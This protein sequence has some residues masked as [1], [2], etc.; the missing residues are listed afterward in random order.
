[1]KKLLAIVLALVLTLSMATIAFAANDKRT[2]PNPNVIDVDL[3]E[4]ATLTD[5]NNSAKGE[6][7]V[8]IDEG[9]LPDDAEDIDP[10]GPNKDDIVYNVV[11]DATAADFTY[12]F[13]KNYNPAT[14][15]YEGGEWQTPKSAPI[16]VTNNSN[17]SISVT[18]D[19]ETGGEKN[20]VKANLTIAGTDDNKTFTLPSAV[21]KATD[22]ATLTKDITVTI[23]DTT[24][25]ST[26]DDFVL[27]NVVIT[28]AGIN[29]TP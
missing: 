10:E 23:D 9:T 26:F 17:T 11:I 12:K 3:S 27:D 6:V 16:T 24:I 14:H 5:E 7:W 2:D 8:L 4:G 13:D 19:W 20:A 21:N 15:K 22:D 1:M 28:I 25:P 29:P 18:A